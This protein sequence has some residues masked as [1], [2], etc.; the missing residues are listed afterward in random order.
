MNSSSPGCESA[1]FCQQPALESA[2]G[3]HGCRPARACGKGRGQHGRVHHLDAANASPS[4][5][6]HIRKLWRSRIARAC[7]GAATLTTRGPNS[8]I[9]SAS[10]ESSSLLPDASESSTLIL[11]SLYDYQHLQWADCVSCGYCA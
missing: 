7:S 1:C 5:W 4:K 10:L 8:V 9:S 3:A 2:Q 11:L 6:F